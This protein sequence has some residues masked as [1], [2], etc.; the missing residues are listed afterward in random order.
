[1]FYRGDI[2][3]KEFTP[4][5]SIRKFTSQLRVDHIHKKNVERKAFNLS[6]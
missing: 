2:Q 4:R 1:M 6:L 5:N 3:E